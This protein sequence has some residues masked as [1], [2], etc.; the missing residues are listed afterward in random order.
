VPGD[1]HERLTRL[2]RFVRQTI[3]DRALRFANARAG[4][5]AE[6][7]QL[8]SQPDE[9]RLL[10]LI[11]GMSAFRT[12]YE[13][14]DRFRWIDMLNG[15]VADGR[16]VGVHLGI[17]ADR[18]NAIPSALASGI[19][20]RLVLRL[21]NEQDYAMAEVPVGVLDGAPPGRGLYNREEVQ[22]AVL[23]GSANVQIQA[24]AV[25]KLAAE[26]R[27]TLDRPAPLPI[28]RLADRVLLSELPPTV[29]GL[30]VLGIADAD[31]TPIGWA[32]APMLVV[33]PPSSGRTTTLASL[34]LS[35]QQSHPNACIAYI[36]SRRSA[37][38]PMPAWKLRADGVDEADTLCRQL[39]DDIQFERANGES[40]LVIIENIADLV[41]GLAE[42]SAL[43]LV[44]ACISHSV[45]VVCDLDISAATY[46]QVLTL[47][48]AQRHGIALQP[49][50][51]DGDQI[52]RTAFP[53]VA[54]GEFPP[55]RGFY[56]R[57]GRAHRVQVALPDLGV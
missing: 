42:T 11:D 36:G 8:A 45:G 22:V 55:G 49:E 28:G 31:L 47:L 24:K 34:A 32:P 35:F 16:Q 37:L 20:R 48:K 25:E 10:L 2:L 38:W 3:D 40:L 30:P 33:G 46:A 26:M 53:S 54:R 50:Q 12:A 6:Y 5:I 44:K 39:A 15:I 23:G 4:S 9:P 1:D 14:G 19:Q 17:T 52:F 57:Q 41:E 7:R 43:E 27:R 29:A 18:V 51:H 21:A 56:V 13:A